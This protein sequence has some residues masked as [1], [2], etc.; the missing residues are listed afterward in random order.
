MSANEICVPVVLPFPGRLSSYLAAQRPTRSQSTSRGKT[1]NPRPRVARRPFCA[2][3][4][5]RI[6]PGAAKTMVVS[7][8]P[9]IRERLRVGGASYVV[10]VHAEEDRFRGHWSCAACGQSGHSGATYCE[11]ATALAWAKSAAS[12]HDLAAHTRE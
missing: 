5:F 8:E 1:F 9:L 6:C 11:V 2:T 7:R 4:A 12:L 3:A 10:E